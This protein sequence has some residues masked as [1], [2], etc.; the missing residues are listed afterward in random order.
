[1]GDVHLGFNL[2]EIFE[3]SRKYFDIVEIREIFGVYCQSSG[4]S[5]KLFI[6][7]LS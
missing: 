1:M 3:V 5:V 4:R 2:S 6:A 7:V